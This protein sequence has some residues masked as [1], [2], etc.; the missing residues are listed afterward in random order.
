MKRLPDGRVVFETLADVPP[1]AMTYASTAWNRT[2]DWRSREPS[3]RDVTPPC[4]AA[5]PAGQDVVDQ[6]RLFAQG[7]VREAGEVMLSANPFP[8]TT[9]RVCPHPCDVACNRGRIDGALDIPGVERALGDALLSER[10]HPPVRPGGGARVAVVGAGPAGLTAAHFLALAGHRVELYAREERPGGLLRT[11]IPPYRLPRA[12]LDAEVERALRPGV[13]FEGGRALGD[14]LDLARLGAES[15]AVLLAIGRHAPRRLGVPGGEARGVV[16]GLALLEA[17]HRG[18]PAPEGDRVVVVGG[19]NTALDCARSLLR[20]GRAVTVAYRRG[21]EEMPA[22]G[23]EVA[24][25]VEEGVAVEAWAIPL[26]VRSRDGRVVGLRLVRARPGEKDASG[27]PRPE[28]IPGSDVELSADLVVVAAGERLDAAVLPEGMVRDGAVAVPADRSAGKVFACG[29]CAGGGGTVAHAIGAGRRAAAELCALL[30]GEPPVVDLLAA[31]RAGRA[32]AG[33]DRIRPAWFPPAPPRAR[34]R[35]EVGPRRL[36][37]AEVRLGFDADSAQAEAARCLGCGTCTGCDV[38]YQLCP[39]RAVLRGAPGGYLADTSRCKGCGVCAQE[40]PRG[41][42][43][44]CE[45]GA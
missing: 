22:F 43:E 19:G 13:R 18:E 2:G 11:G 36:G 40:C 28:P 30:G 16:D 20:R 45:V 9:G 42:V 39:D 32:V 5:C 6:V 33:F 44:L 8:A 34:G 41:A 21:R 4:A 7:R 3:F 14:G 31:R 35:A 24:E 37:D 17:L 15:D 12:V 27:R 26:E 1:V 38:C 23:D 25:A 29:D 10:L